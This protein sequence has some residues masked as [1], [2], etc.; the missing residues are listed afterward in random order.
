METSVI[1]QVVCNGMLLFKLPSDFGFFQE[2][3]SILKESVKTSRADK[4]F[5]CTS[6]VVCCVVCTQHAKIPTNGNVCC[7]KTLSLIR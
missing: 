1:I 4:E 7:R 3:A 5:Y 6:T 2:K